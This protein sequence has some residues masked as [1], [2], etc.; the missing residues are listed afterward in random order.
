MIKNG[1]K[2]ITPI[3]KANGSHNSRRKNA[4]RA[5]ADDHRLAADA[6]LS[7]DGGD[8]RPE[9]DA[10]CQ[11]LQIITDH[12]WAAIRQAND[13]PTIFR[14]GGVAVRLE[15]GDEGEPIIREVT[16]HRM[17]HF[18]ARAARWNRTVGDETRRVTPPHVVVNDVM[19]SPDQ[20]LPILTRI[21]EA[22][23]FAPDGTL[24]TEP[25]YHSASRTFFAP[26]PGFAVPDV[27]LH[28]TAREVKA[29][30]DL[31]CDELLGDF[32]FVNDGELA[33]A[34]AVLL[35]PFARD[36]VSGA[37]PLHLIE[38][39]TAGTGATLLADM[40]NW[41]ATGRPI[42]TMTEGRDEDEWRK[43]ITAKLRRGSQFVLIDNIRRRLD[44]AALSAAITS[45]I[46][47]DRIIRTSQTVQIPIR[48][49]W[50]ATGNNP[51]VSFEIARRTIRIRLDASL[52][53]PW[54]RTGFK[55]PRLKTWTIENRG[56]LVS[57]ALTMIRAWLAAGCPP[58]S[59]TLG[60]FEN[61]SEVVGGILDVSKIKGFLS[62]LGDFY[63]QSDAESA[64][65]RSFMTAWW[66]KFGVGEVTVAQLFP[67]VAADSCLTLGDGSEQ[68]QRVVLGKMLAA[69]RDRVFELEIGDAPCRVVLK[70]DKTVRRATLWKLQRS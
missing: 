12:A 36:L 34:V 18:M 67:L 49:V 13:P 63:S 17:R 45:P 33:H 4:G 2:L 44:S 50:L 25:G 53:R 64:G 59:H 69:S 20:Q 16:V 14:Q 40:L 43:R 9:I 57:A 5:A 23:V 55:H 15:H 21:V 68:S 39:P 35:L 1:K 60:M 58:C 61:W 38:K 41:P 66:E 46:W 7:T 31:I 37:T 22:P 8:G 3:A 6:Q 51:A 24:Q 27:S 56:R 54:L 65:W 11:D 28:P 48:C 10:S 62:N 32:P 47:E 30:R 52:E 26:A 70:G 29:A 42:S 19:A